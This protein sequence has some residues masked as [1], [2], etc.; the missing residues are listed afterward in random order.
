MVLQKPS[1]L[2]KWATEDKQDGIHGQ[3]NVLVPPPE[4]Q[5]IGYV[6]KEKPN[7]QYL[8]WL[9]R[10]IYDWIA[11]YN[12]KLDFSTKT[13]IPEWQGLDVIPSD[14]I[15]NYSVQGNICFFNCE[16]SYGGN[17]DTSDLQIKNLP[18]YSNNLITLTQ[19]VNVNRAG[20]PTL[21]LNHV[22]SAFIEPTSNK[23]EF[24]QEDLTTGVT[25]NFKAQ[26]A[27]HLLITGFYFIEE[28]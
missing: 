4:K 10:T 12:S 20:G 25:S 8:N 13:L 6:Y 5:K 17:G 16:L 18:Y 23:L 3:W 26:S 24:K 9:F 19:S 27:G 15:F 21:P 14:S 7:R 1:N 11:Y 22:I 28:V 2:P